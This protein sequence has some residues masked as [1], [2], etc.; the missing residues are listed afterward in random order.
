MQLTVRKVAEVDEGLRVGHGDGVQQRVEAQVVV[1]ERHDDTQFGQPQPQANELGPV[2]H[3]ER[4]HVTLAVAV[5]QEHARHLVRV[6]LDLEQAQTEPFEIGSVQVPLTSRVTRAERQTSTRSGT[7]LGERK[8]MVLAL[9]AD[10]VGA[11][12]RHL[13][14][15]LGDGHV[16]LGQA[17]HA[18]LH[19][20]E[21][22]EG[23]ATEG[24]W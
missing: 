23:P 24:C 8:L 5:L 7:H 2:V 16:A 3:E 6:L 13:S 20:E 4:H 1:D 14:E 9:E 17:V 21:A 10:L 18:P 19:P 22:R 15:H 11:L 12:G